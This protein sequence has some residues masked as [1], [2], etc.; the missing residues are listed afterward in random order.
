MID[1]KTAFALFAAL[2]ILSYFTLDGE[3]RLVA[4]GALALF[5]VRVYIVILQRKQKERESALPVDDV[6][7]GGN[8]GH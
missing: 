1:S 2:A 5:A 4:L 6:P 7:P 8:S 3:P